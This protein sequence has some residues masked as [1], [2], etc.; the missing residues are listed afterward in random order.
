MRL[1][2]FRRCWRYAP[3]S[4]VGQFA[5]GGPMAELPTGTVTLLFTDVEGSTQLL[6]QLGDRYPAVLDEHRGLLRVAFQ[7]AGGRFVVML[8]HA[9]CSALV[10]ATTL[11]RC[12]A[13]GRRSRG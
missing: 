7:A 4:G 3:A 2:D 12:R 13:A 6:R 5:Q 1:V 11:F 9:S 10:R 8:G